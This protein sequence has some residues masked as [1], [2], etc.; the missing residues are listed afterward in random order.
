MRARSGTIP[1]RLLTV[2]ASA[3]FSSAPVAAADTLNLA[4]NWFP[5]ADHT[6]FRLA[7]DRGYYRAA[8]LDVQMESSK[9]SGDVIAKVD[10][11]HSDVG[12]ADTATVIAAMSRGTRVKLVGMLFDRTPLNFFSRADLPLTVP[13]DLVGRT[14]G[15]P[16]G[17][18]QRQVWPAFA[19]LNGIDAASVTWVNIEPAAKIVAL[20]EKRVDAVGDYVHGKPLYERAMSV[21]EMPWSKFGFEMYSLGIIASEKT[22][23]DKPAALRAFLQ[24]SYSG[25]RDTMANQK[26]AL[27]SYK[28]LVPE[29][30]ARMT[31][32]I[33]PLSLDMMMSQRYR[34]NGLGWI[35]QKTICASVEIVN[36]DMDLANKVDCREVYTTEFLPRIE[37]PPTAHQ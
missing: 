4:L 21:V 8:G 25:L 36:T 16:A 28:K 13:K 35:D 12:L 30:D 6:A 1:T 33:L 29:L 19:K 14:I 27:A 32:A 5:T 20:V 11:G 3:F 15:A 26:A 7:E 18:T 31:E 23:A 34:E 2:I 24:A 22:I 17:D 37:P 10:A 9:G